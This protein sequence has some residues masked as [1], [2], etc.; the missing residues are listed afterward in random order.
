MA[1]HSEVKTGLS[2]LEI[3]A[4]Q[5]LFPTH[6]RQLEGMIVSIYENERPLAGLAGWLDW[7][8]RGALSDFIQSGFIKGKEGE[9]AYLPVV[10]QEKTFHLILVGA[11]N[12]PVPGQRGSLPLESLRSL[13][14]NLASLRLEKLGIS[15]KDFEDTMIQSLKG[16]PLWIVRAP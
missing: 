15:L 9:C 13:K 5:A 10:K 2:F 8:F 12:T 14:K 6:R 1:R 4:E 3:S 7:R 11:G 16:L